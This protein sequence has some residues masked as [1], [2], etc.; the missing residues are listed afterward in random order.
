P[1][2][3]FAQQPQFNP[4]PQQNFQQPPVSQFQAP[5]FPPA[6]NFAPQQP[7]FSAPANNFAQQPQFNTAPVVFDN[8]ESQQSNVSP[9][10]KE[11]NDFPDF[12]ATPSIIN[13][14]LEP[15]KK[16]VFSSSP[17][18][19]SN[20]LPPQPSPV[21][22]FNPEESFSSPSS[23][24]DEISN[25]FS[26]LDNEADRAQPEEQIQAN[27]VIDQQNEIDKT[28]FSLDSRGDAALSGSSSTAS[29]T[30]ASDED[31]FKYDEPEAV[32]EAKEKKVV[33]EINIESL[34]KDS[35]YTPNPILDD[36]S[37]IEDFVYRN[38]D[39]GKASFDKAGKNDSIK[40]DPE[41]EIDLSFVADSKIDG[42]VSQDLK[43]KNKTENK[44]E[45]D[46]VQSSKKNQFK[47][48]QNLKKPFSQGGNKNKK[49]D[50]V[51]FSKLKENDSSNL[52]GG[53]YQDYLETSDSN[54]K[55]L[56]LF[57]ERVASV[58]SNY[59][60]ITGHL[61]DSTT[62]MMQINDKVVDQAKDI[63]QLKNATQTASGSSLQEQIDDLRYD[64]DSMEK[65][66]RSL[67]TETR[68][69]QNETTEQLAALGA[70]AYK[71]GGIMQKMELLKVDIM[72]IQKK[73]GEAMSVLPDATNAKSV[74]VKRQDNS[75]S[76]NQQQEQDYQNN[77]QR[78]NNRFDRQ[79]R[80]QDV[81]K[82][83][84]K[85]NSSSSSANS[86]NNQESNQADQ[87]PTKTSNLDLR[88]IL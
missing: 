47:D 20:P 39:S 55:K 41:N 50:F 65:E 44:P 16:N 48:N 27:E 13:S 32:P 11:F 78:P 15:A 53:I 59:E 76:N 68:R 62:K 64:I 8:I 88:G 23:K 56:T 29:K 77:Q 14:T 79:S 52:L 25:V 26:E 46:N 3:N 86:D 72:N 49:E 24:P 61:E 81:R 45:A 22:F 66:F 9:A 37:A 74:E 30:T 4:Q 38:S 80:G 84:Q 36:T 57:L 54:Q 67:K 5:A 6:N 69:K 21:D 85:L 71:S 12:S 87:T 33:N 17:E 63:Q 70:D 28:G 40:P 34:V 10:V 19:P 7:D 60:K 51:N 18:T 43:D 42:A 31:P 35:K 1:A 82:N 83:F 2:N 75:N 58:L 73:I